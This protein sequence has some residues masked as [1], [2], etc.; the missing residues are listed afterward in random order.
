MAQKPPAKGGS[1]V[2]VYARDARARPW[3]IF[4]GKCRNVKSLSIY[5]IER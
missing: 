4:S 1:G 2:R 5:L 3:L